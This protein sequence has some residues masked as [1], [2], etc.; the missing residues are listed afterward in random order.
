MRKVI[1]DGYDPAIDPSLAAFL[2]HLNSSDHGALIVDSFKA[3]TRN[4]EKLFHVLEFLLSRGRVFATSNFYL[5][6]GHVERRVKPLH[7]GHTTSEMLRNLSQTSGL[8]YQ[9]RIT[10]SR[11]VKE[12]KSSQ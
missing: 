10:L 8:G 1:L 2:L 3:L 4:A 9:H 12:A 6:N 5:E 7:A 11:Y